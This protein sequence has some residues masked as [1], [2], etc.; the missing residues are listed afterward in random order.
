[1]P[2]YKE[3]NEVNEV[4]ELDLGHTLR[5]LL[6][7]GAEHLVVSGN[8]KADGEAVFAVMGVKTTWEEP[9]SEE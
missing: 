2:Q 6:Q 1:M 4:G 7:Q 3:M 9:A 5:G 8:I